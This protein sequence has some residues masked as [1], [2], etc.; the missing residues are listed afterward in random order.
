MAVRA[1]WP[2][3]ISKVPTARCIPISDRTPRDFAG[4]SGSSLFPGGIPS[5]V[6]PETPGS[7]HEGGELGYSLVHAYGA[8]LDNPDLVVACVIGD[9]EA[10]TGPLAASWHS[11]KFLDPVGDGA[12]LPILHLNGYKIANPTVL[13][14]IGDDELT[15]LLEGYGHRPIFVVGDEP[16]DVHQQLA[17]A[18]DEALDDIAG[19]QTVGTPRLD[20]L[21]SGMAHDRAAD[22]EGL[23]RTEGSRRSAH[24]GDV[25]GP[26]GARGRG[27][28]QPWA[29][30]D[31]RDMDEKLPTRRAVR[32]LGPACEKIS[33][34][35]LAK[36]ARR[37]SANPHANGGL[38]LQD[39]E[40]PDFRDYSVEVERPAPIRSSR[41]GCSADSSA[42]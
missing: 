16:S 29:P 28:D 8:A 15:R 13:A 18:L 35:C 21:P 1:S 10:E 37:M 40:L 30:P 12:V 39:L 6:A 42:T 4:C 33:P 31:T 32:R 38:L 23:D 24:R 11:N 19:I 26:P 3:P 25:P 22:P 34:P 5:H 36:G 20:Q 27:A 17:A 7:I 41:H 14:R 2:M 9:G